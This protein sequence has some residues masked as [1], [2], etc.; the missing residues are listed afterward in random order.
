MVIQET[1]NPNGPSQKPEIFAR[2]QACAVVVQTAHEAAIFVVDSV[3]FPEGQKNLEK[4]VMKSLAQLRKGHARQPHFRRR[5][6][7][8]GR[9]TYNRGSACS[10]EP[11][12]QSRCS[13]QSEKRTSFHL[14]V[15]LSLSPT[16]LDPNAS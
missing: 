16:D 4:L 1:V 5:C 8:D 6:R 7:S 11:E 12:M 3:L 15:L 13:R 2:I 10:R 9:S 14:S